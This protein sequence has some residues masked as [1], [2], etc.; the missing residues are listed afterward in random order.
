MEG[1]CLRHQDYFEWHLSQTWPILTVAHFV[2]AQENS[3]G[4][5]SNGRTSVSG[6]ESW[7]SNPCSPATGKSMNDRSPAATQAIRFVAAEAR[8]GDLKLGRMNS[9]ELDPKPITP[10][11]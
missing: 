11:A 5:S 7:G 6:T 4:E 10:I 1:R 3:I 2:G 8:P 9:Q